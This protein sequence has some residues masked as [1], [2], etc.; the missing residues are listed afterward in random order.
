[1]TSWPSLLVIQVILEELL[2]GGL[3]GRS[4]FPQT[5]VLGVERFIRLGRLL[6]INGLARVFFT[7][8]GQH[9]A[10]NLR[11]LL[12]RRPL[13]SLLHIGDEEGAIDRAA[14]DTRPAQD[15]KFDFVAGDGKRTSLSEEMLIVLDEGLAL[16][17]NQSKTQCNSIHTLVAMANIQVG[18]HWL[19]QKR[20][21]NQRNI[22]NQALYQYQSPPSVA[23]APQART[24]TKTRVTS[25]IY[26]REKLESKLVNLLSLRSARN[27]IDEIEYV[28]QFSSRYYCCGAKIYYLRRQDVPS[29]DR[30]YAWA[31]Q[32]V[33]TALVFAKDGKTLMTV[34]RNRRKGRRGLRPTRS[35]PRAGRRRR[36]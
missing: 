28:Y 10:P 19:F 36:R 3:G 30:R 18:T 1:M 25:T 16:A 5:L 22:L 14:G 8:L 35:T 7:A 26:H 15:Q 13:Q 9:R 29:S 12:H 17:E 21:L 31:M 34:W 11:E 6:V 24:K 2:A 27:V 20:G 23:Q 32:L 4:S 33:G